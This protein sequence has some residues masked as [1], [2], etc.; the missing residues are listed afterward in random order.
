MASEEE[1]DLLTRMKEHIELLEQEVGRL[2]SAPLQ[3]VTVLKTVDETR[4][5]ITPGAIVDLPFKRDKEGKVTKKRIPAPP[6]GTLLLVNRE[7][8]VI[9][10]TEMPLAGPEATVKRVFEGDMMEIEG[11]LGG[12]ASYIFKGAVAD[13]VKPGDLIQLDRSGSVA[14]K[15]IPKDRSAH[16]VET[17]TGVSW[18][19][20]GGQDIAKDAL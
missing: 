15:I 17:A 11:G 10:P 9:E 6:V 8:A 13:C 2:M 3:L 7:G 4:V 16:V 14:L 20:I 12:S 5:M 19:D 1:K 18:D